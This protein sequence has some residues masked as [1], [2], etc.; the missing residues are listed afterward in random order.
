MDDQPTATRPPILCAKLGC[1][2]KATWRPV[3]IVRPLKGPGQA[4]GYLNL[5]LCDEHKKEVKRLADILTDEGWQMIH[6][7]FCK[8]GVAEPSRMRSTLTWSPI[9]ASANG[10]N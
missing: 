2:A 1:A 4:P 9:V 3:I 6:D 10:K 7:E 5:P 8:A